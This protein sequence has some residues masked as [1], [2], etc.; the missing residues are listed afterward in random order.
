[1]EHENGAKSFEVTVTHY[2]GDYE[3]N[4]QSGLCGR[5]V[6]AH[7]QE[8]WVTPPTDRPTFCAFDQFQLPDDQNVK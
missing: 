2:H 6:N 5:M 1:M 4:V 8:V 3:T 7:T